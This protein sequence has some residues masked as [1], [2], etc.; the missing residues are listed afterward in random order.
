MLTLHFTCNG[1]ERAP[2]ASRIWLKP[3]DVPHGYDAGERFF[4]RAEF[5]IISAF[6]QCRFQIPRHEQQ[7]GYDEH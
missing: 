2:H 5:F 4:F 1:G 6:L 7:I 3:N